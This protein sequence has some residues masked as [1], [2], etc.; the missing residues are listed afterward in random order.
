[1]PAARSG[2]RLAE[3]PAKAAGIGRQLLDGLGHQRGE[4]VA[5]PWMRLELEGVRRLVQGNEG[6]EAVERNSKARRSG[7]DVWL[8][9]V[10]PAARYRGGCEQA[11]VVL[12]EHLASQEA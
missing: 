10:E 4:V 6:A 1:M 2:E 11:D 3:A 12:P 9:E 8:D 5:Q 7:V